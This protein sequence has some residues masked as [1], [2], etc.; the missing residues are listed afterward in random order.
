VE[1]TDVRESVCAFELFGAKV[2]RV[3]K[4]ALGGVVKGEDREETKK[5]RRFFRWLPPLPT[6]NRREG[7]W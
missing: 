4:G 7:F 6:S 2:G 3:L 1:L 5:V